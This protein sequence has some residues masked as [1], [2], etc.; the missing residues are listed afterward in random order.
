MWFTKIADKIRMICLNAED[1]F[2]MEFKKAKALVLQRFI[3]VMPQIDEA[4]L[5]V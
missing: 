4:V 5:L 2:D 1:L 3:D